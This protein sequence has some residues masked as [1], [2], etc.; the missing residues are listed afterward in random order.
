MPDIIEYLNTEYTANDVYN[1]HLFVRKVNDERKDAAEEIVRLRG[2]GYGAVRKVREEYQERLTHVG[3]KYDH[4]L[5][6]L[7]LL[8]S[9]ADGIVGEIENGASIERL[10]ELAMIYRHNK[11]EGAW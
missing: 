10:Q 2:Y 9:Y 7:Y 5:E 4:V 8:D 1:V 3:L 6:K 11:K